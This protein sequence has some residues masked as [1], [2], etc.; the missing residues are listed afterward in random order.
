MSLRSDG[1]YC[2]DRCGG[3]V[4]NGGV[5]LAAVVS[6]MDDAGQAR[7]LHFCRQPRKG[8]PHGCAAHILSPANTAAYRKAHS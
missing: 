7:V 2:C 3:D 4:G 1:S 6:D 5:H 8:A